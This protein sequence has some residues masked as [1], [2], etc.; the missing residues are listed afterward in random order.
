MEALHRILIGVRQEQRPICLAT[1]KEHV[2]NVTY[3]STDNTYREK[4]DK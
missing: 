3:T 4:N 1:K 2:C